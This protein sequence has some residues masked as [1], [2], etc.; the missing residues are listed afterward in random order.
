MDG[1]RRQHFLAALVGLEDPPPNCE[2]VRDLRERGLLEEPGV[3]V[4]VADEVF[5]MP[6]ELVESV[7]LEHGGGAVGGERNNW[8]T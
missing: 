2:T 1:F 7:R 3:G 5:L 6:E 8:R 4:S